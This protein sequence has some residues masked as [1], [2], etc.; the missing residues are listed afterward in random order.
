[1]DEGLQEL[2]LGFPEEYH[3]PHAEQLLLLI[4]PTV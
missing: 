2:G 3:L 1:M 4:T